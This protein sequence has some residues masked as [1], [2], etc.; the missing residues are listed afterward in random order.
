MKKTMFLIILVALCTQTF[1]RPYLEV[2]NYSTTPAVLYPGTRGYLSV[3]ISNTG[4]SATDIASAVYTFEG[5]QSTIEMGQLGSGSNS[6]ISIPFK[7]PETF[8]GG[9]ELITVFLHYTYSDS[10]NSVTTA[11]GKAGSASFSI[12]LEVNQYDPFTVKTIGTIESISAGEK[13]PVKLE[14]INSGGTVNNVI[15]SIASNSS[16]YLDGQSRY[17]IG[18]IN[19]N[20]SVNSTFTIGTESDLQTGTYVI[21]ITVTYQDALSQPKE[22][23]Y[24]IGPL[25]ILETSSQ[26]RLTVV[27]KETVEIGSEVTFLINFENTGSSPVSAVV[28]MDA[29][30]ALTPMGAQNIY[31]DS[32]APGSTES[33]EIHIGISSSVSAGYY[34]LPVNLTTSS[35]QS[36]I[37]NFGINAEA[38]P[39]INVVFTESS[40]SGEIQ[41]TNV[42]NSQ[43]RSV[44]VI[45]SDAS[46]TITESFLGTLNVDDYGTVSLGSSNSNA[47]TVTIN[48]KDSVNQAHTVKKSLSES[49]SVSVNQQNSSSSSSFSGVAR[50][51]GPLGMLGGSTGS[52]TDPILLGGVVLVIAVGGF[53]VYRRFFSKPK[54][55][56]Q[57]ITQ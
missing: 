56:E 31:F 26:Y 45:I 30:D 40:G 21:P 49:G 44:N 18:S 29:T 11:S 10:T 36:L 41:I 12:P 34:V 35:G 5:K 20:S 6:R 28:N 55:K 14:L 8:N 3:E 19:S 38:T 7:I 53:F 9:I 37:Y 13:V 22:Q 2:G 25:T 52:Q 16:F 57:K 43:I 17:V 50:N 54:I 32:V 4:D 27:P 24:I 51:R 47:I 15:I 42:G 33:K 48:F 39:E 1:A 46:G 23:T